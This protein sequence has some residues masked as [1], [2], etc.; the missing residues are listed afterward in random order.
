MA[1]QPPCT[2]LMKYTVLKAYDIKGSCKTGNIRLRLHLREPTWMGLERKH[3]E[4]EC[5][6]YQ[7]TQ[8]FHG[9]HK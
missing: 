2:T 3:P 4:T 8:L 9:H 5:S 1:K 6:I 7:L